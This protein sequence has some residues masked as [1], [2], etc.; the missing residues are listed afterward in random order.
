[1]TVMNYTLFLFF[2]AQYFDIIAVFADRLMYSVRIKRHTL[3]FGH[4][5]I[6]M[7]HI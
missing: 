4:T 7:K 1:M 5:F 6:F 3:I 2:L